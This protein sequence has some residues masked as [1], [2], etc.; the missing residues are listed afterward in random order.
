MDLTVDQVVFPVQSIISMWSAKL[1]KHV[2]AC[3]SSSREDSWK[4]AAGDRLAIETHTER[5][6]DTFYVM[7]QF[8]CPSRN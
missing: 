6:S 8:C 5:L 3:S 7:N 4:T 2:D 1:E